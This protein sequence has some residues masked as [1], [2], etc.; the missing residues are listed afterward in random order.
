MVPARLTS[1]TWLLSGVPSGAVNASWTMTVV[2]LVYAPP[3]AA[4]V[5]DTSTLKLSKRVSV[6]R[7]FAVTKIE[8]S[9]E[10]LSKLL[11]TAEAKAHGWLGQRQQIAKTLEDIRDTATKLLTDLGHGAAGVAAVVQRGRK[12]RPPGSKN[13]AATQPVS[14]RKRRKMSAEARRR[15][16]EAQKARWA[17]QKAGEKKSR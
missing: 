17:K 2:A 1:G 12:E 11:G 9:A 16:S 5:I 13:K 7:M 10:K 4:A 14:R 15:I 3:P 8:D 6:S